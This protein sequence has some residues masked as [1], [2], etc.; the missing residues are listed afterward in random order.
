MAELD[1]QEQDRSSADLSLLE[2]IPQSRI[3]LAHF[4]EDT[5]RQLYDAFHLELRYNQVT[6]ELTLRVTITADTV[7]ALA[8]AV[9]A[10][11]GN[12]GAGAGAGPTVSA[13][14]CVEALRARGGIRTRTSFRT[15]DF[16][17]AVSAIPP[18][19][20]DAY[21]CVPGGPGNVGTIQR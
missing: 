19:G 14:K 5:Q 21:R 15:A 12:A 16:K 9:S 1:R 17:S 4:P 11:A 2:E 8:A 18:P 7:A 10:A 13:E 3:D 20:R 6:S